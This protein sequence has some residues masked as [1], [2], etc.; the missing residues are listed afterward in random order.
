VYQ[1]IAPRYFFYWFRKKNY[2][3]LQIYNNGVPIP[4]PCLK[5]NRMWTAR[6]NKGILTS[7]CRK[8][9]ALLPGYITFAKR[10]TDAEL[11]TICVKG[12]NCTF[13]FWG[14]PT[15]EVT[16]LWSKKLFENILQG[17]IAGMLLFYNISNIILLKVHLRVCIFVFKRLRFF[18]RNYRI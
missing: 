3:G 4:S 18:Y 11:L 12:L 8:T 7:F 13:P 6:P 16:T 1:Q 9:I 17:G 2:W 15:L 14:V 10:F 5:R